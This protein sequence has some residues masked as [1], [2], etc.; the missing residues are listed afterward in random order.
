MTSDQLPW[1]ENGIS[2][3]RLADLERQL[4]AGELSSGMALGMAYAMGFDSGIARAIVELNR[5]TDRIVRVGNK[6]DPEIQS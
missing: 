2:R 5:K 4:R 3:D 6:H 1:E